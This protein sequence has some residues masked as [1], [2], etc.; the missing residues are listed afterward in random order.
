L[1]VD[2]IVVRT[3]KNNLAI[4][5][6]LR[7]QFTLF[8][9]KVV[10]LGEMRQFLAQL[11]RKHGQL[12]SGTQQKISFARSQEAAADHQRARPFHIEEDGQ[13]VHL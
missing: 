13:M 12:A 5:Q 6:I 7:G 2:H 9:L 1:L 8:V 10:R 11:R 3:A 4:C